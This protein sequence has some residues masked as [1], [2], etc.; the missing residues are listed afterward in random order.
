MNFVF[1]FVVTVQLKLA[2]PHAIETVM[3]PLV[4]DV[5][6]APRTSMRPSFAI[7]TSCIGT[8][9]VTEPL[10][11]VELATA[12]ETPPPMPIKF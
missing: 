2:P 4:I 7:C 12:A 6:I 10:E 5:T 8:V 11:N 9:V 3:V 1:E